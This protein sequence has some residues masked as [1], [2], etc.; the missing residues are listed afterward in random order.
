MFLQ[1]DNFFHKNNKK[2]LM[3]SLTKGKGI[4][5]IIVVAFKWYEVFQRLRRAKIAKR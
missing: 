2:E 4:I 3:T 5:K 1:R